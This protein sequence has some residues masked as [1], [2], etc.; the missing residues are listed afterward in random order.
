MKKLT[1]IFLFLMIMPL[2]VVEANGVPYVTFTYSSTNGRFVYTQDAYI[3]LSRRQTFGNVTLDNPQ[4][5]TFDDDDV[6]Y[7]ADRDL[8]IIIVY[9]EVNQ[10]TKTIGEGI[11]EGPTGVHIGSDGH[12][13]VADF[14]TKKAY[15]FAPDLDDSYELVQTY[16]KPLNSPFFSESDPFDPTKITTDNANNVYVL[17][18]GNINGL[19]QY[20][21]DGTFFGYFGGNSIP[22]S[23]QNTVTFLFFDEETRRNLFQIIP[24]PVYNIATDQDG[25]IL[26][27]TKGLDGYLKLNIANFVLNRSVWGFDNNEDLYVGPY[28]TIFAVTS[29]GYIVEYGPDGSVLFIFSGTDTSNIQGL[30]QR[31]TSIA[32]NSKSQIYVLDNQTASLQVF[33]PT[34]FANLVHTAIELYQ[35]G[36]YVEALEPW[37]QVLEQ[38]ALFDLANQG[39]GDAYFAEMNYEEALY[40]YEIARNQIGYSDAFWEVR[41]DVL[42][43]SGAFIIVF[44]FAVLALSIGGKYLKLNDILLK[45]VNILNNKIKDYK[46]VKELKFGFYL[47]THPVDGY[48]GIKR[49]NKAS[50]LSATIYFLL[51]FMV[52]LI[53]I[54]ETNFLFN[55]LIRSQIDIFEQVIS[56][57]LPYLLFVLANYLVC[58]IRDGEGSFKDVYIATS[59]SLLPAIIGLPL[60]TFISQGLTLNEAFLFDFG[61]LV[62]YVLTGFYLVMMVKEIHYYEMKATVGNIL[63]TIFTAIMILVVVFI[64]YLLLGEVVQLILD[65]IREVTVRG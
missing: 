24:D 42:L 64:V 57:F 65:I 33:V 17:L 58:S 29:E 18:A 3:P 25:L 34:S 46:L 23:W 36:R 54:F 6:M 2:L 35:D 4:D 8:G 26:T 40:Y 61:M 50:Y 28:E 39:L 56:I 16:E 13:Y 19:A 59:Y 47:M 31:P 32:V 20:K 63:I 27:T 44:L 10:V 43:N 14:I 51:F 49:E 52:Y 60:M 48:Y 11:L 30:F 38:N 21:N 1:L 62:I 15:Q 55:P 45:P 53:Y 5:I 37:K 12:V 9:D 7:I 41:N 22:A